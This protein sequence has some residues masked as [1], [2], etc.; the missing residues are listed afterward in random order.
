[1]ESGKL[2][3]GWQEGIKKLIAEADRQEELTPGDGEDLRG[4]P[5]ASTG[6]ESGD[7]GN[8]G[9]KVI[10][11]R[12]E[13]LFKQLELGFERINALRKARGLPPV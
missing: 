6:F 10:S 12:T 1:M 4:A 11:E 5:P 13:R 8:S 2:K 9:F 3:P 7:P